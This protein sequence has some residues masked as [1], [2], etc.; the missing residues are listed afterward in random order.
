MVSTSIVPETLTSYD[1]FVGGNFCGTSTGLIVDEVRISN[2]IRVSIE[3]Y[4]VLLPE[5]IYLMQNYPNP[6]NPV[7]TIQYALPKRSDV[8]LVIYT[9][10]GEE[11]KRFSELG[12]QSG[13]HEFIWDASN[14]ASGVYL[15]RLRAGDFIQTKKMLLLK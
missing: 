8:S 10:L 15:Y 7:T 3:D 12:V 6:F 5:K 4:D 14:A 1:V 13:H 9:I 2:I 11:V